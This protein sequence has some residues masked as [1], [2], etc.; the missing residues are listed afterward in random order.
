MKEPQQFSSQFEAERAIAEMG[1]EGIL[2]PVHI[3]GSKWL[4]TDNREGTIS[5]SQ[6]YHM[7]VIYYKN[8]GL[9]F[10]P[11]AINRQ[12]NQIWSDAKSK[13]K[14]KRSNKK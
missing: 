9:K 4:L 12:V 7:V 1:Q 3:P 10:D 8:E 2:K 14:K 11:L 6:L 13:T 5:R